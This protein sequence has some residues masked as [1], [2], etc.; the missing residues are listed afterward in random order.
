MSVIPRRWLPP[1]A[2][3]PEV[4][5]LGDATLL[6]LR[7]RPT[8]ARRLAREQWA[9]IKEAERTTGARFHKGQPL[10]NLGVAEFL[11][12]P[13][14]ARVWFLAAHIEDSRTWSRQPQGGRQ[15]AQS[16]RAIYGYR[17]G[18]LRAIARRARAEHEIEP[19]ELAALILSEGKTE[20]LRLPFP[21]PGTGDDADLTRVPAD[22]RVFVGGTYSEAWPSIVT[23]SW[24]V[25]GAGMFPV[26][27]K[28][29]QDRPGESPR[30]KSFRLLDMCR[31]AIFDAA[32]ASDW[33]QEVAHIASEHA[34]STLI[35]HP[36][37]RLDRAVGGWDM[38]PDV[39]EIPDLV[40]VNVDS[41]ERRRS[42]VTRWL[43]DTA[44]RPGVAP[45]VLDIFQAPGS[46]T[47]WAPYDHG[48]QPRYIGLAQ[49]SN[50]RYWPQAPTPSGAETFIDS[51]EG[52]EAVGSGG[53]YGI[54]GAEGFAEE[55]DD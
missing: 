31:I 46:A 5:R 7:D 44:P 30:R 14:F 10:H 6:A 53:D 2:I 43:L 4:Q 32:H 9:L 45:N 22:R 18:Q 25:A 48:P 50:T 40:H 41:D 36:V 42:A 47:K 52:R 20:R 11:A 39:D 33:R 54:L 15:A 55:P 49:G 35:L 19:F 12:N 16:L 27:V 26:V 1:T 3:L 24:G 37:D 23:I 38:M 51:S 13:E 17:T 21:E 34:C 29:Y 8:T 28:C